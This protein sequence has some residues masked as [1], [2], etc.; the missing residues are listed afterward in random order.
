MPRRTVALFCDGV[1]LPANIGGI[2]R[3][4]DAVGVEEVIF[5]N[6]ETNPDSRKVRQVARSTHQW[7]RYRLA[8]DGQAALEQLIE[9]GYQAIALELT[10]RSIPLSDIRM[11]PEKK[12][13]LIIGSEKSGVSWEALN[14]VDMCYYIP[15]YGRNSSMNVVQAT[16]IALF[17]LTKP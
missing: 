13:V 11:D 3:L 1:S 14:I 4:A 6:T 9:A 8:A 17:E 16:A 12:I 15:V 7:V 5:A 2:L 10:D